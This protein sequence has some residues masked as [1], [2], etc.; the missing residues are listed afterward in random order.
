MKR[1]DTKQRQIH[2]DQRLTVLNILPNRLRNHI[3]A[4]TGEAFGTASFLFL[5]FSGTQVAN[6]AATASAQASGGGNSI[7]SAPNASSLMM[8]ALSF[9]FSLAVNAW[10]FFRVSGG[11][12]NPSVT[13]ALALV[14]AVTWI[15]ALVALIAQLAG[16][17][18]AAVIV[19]ALFPGKFAVTTTL[20]N[21]VGL[22][23]GVFIEALLT[24]V[25]IFCM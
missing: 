3:V 5:A 15:R 17:M 6:A 23:R 14:G 16:A 4:G 9:G 7:A 1:Q 25:L 24:T 11:L 10:V 8:I 12:F 19:R 18:V 13:L 20:N 2:T 22:A 21:G